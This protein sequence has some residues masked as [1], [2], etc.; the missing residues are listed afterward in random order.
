MQLN[1]YDLALRMLC[2]YKTSKPFLFLM[3][4]VATR[5]FKAFV[6]NKA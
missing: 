6:G 2:N 5:H 4:K 1:V 3:K